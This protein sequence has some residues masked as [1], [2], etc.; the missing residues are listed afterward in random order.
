MKHLLL[1]LMLVVLLPGCGSSSSESIA[2]EDRVGSLP[3]QV[4]HPADNP[5]SEDKV[6]LGRMLF[7]DPILSGNRDVACATC[8]H[9]DNAYAENIDLSIGVGGVGLSESREFG[10]LIKRNSPTI[11]NAA[12][13]GINAAGEVDPA[14]TVM[15]WDNRS[16]SL[17]AQALEPILS[18]E[19]MRGDVYSLED[20]LVIVSQRLSE[21]P[22]Y[23]EMFADAF[24]DNLINSDRIAKAIAAFE[25]T[26]IANNSP[27]DRYARG[28]DSAL[29]AQELRGLAAFNDAGC[30]GC[31][32]GPMFSDFELHNLGV[33]HNSKLE[34]ID[35]GEDGAFRTPT[36]RNVEL[37]A[38]YMHNGTE[39]DLES[40]IAFYDGISNPSNDPDIEAIDLD[41]DPDTVAA[42]AAFLRS[43]T[44]TSFDKTIPSNVPSGLQPGGN[45]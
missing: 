36:L 25:R 1:P 33:S 23:Q 29:N 5:T 44:D 32:N 45:I 28:D 9:P 11:V 34:E 35:E 38:P 14:N 42:I 18:K 21:I 39:R 6:E 24:G 2:Q 40:A 26:I 12:F 30:N 22:E 8:H 17:E 7:W 3:L 27:F 19:E 31:H 20:A 13:N 37:T 4:A 41:D 10:T 16:E 43:L 15:F